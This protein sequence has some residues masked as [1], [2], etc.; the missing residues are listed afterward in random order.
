[1]SIFKD[2][3]ELLHY[4]DCVIVPNFGAFVLKSKSAHIQKNEFFPPSK[5]VSFNV[6][7][8]DNDGLLAK[9]ISIEKKISYKKSLILISEEVI[10]FKESLNKDLIIDTE[11]LG[12][13]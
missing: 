12:I 4:N 10:S 5:Y 3:A 1:M 7:L 9:H 6:M 8:K 11:C 2:V 13:F